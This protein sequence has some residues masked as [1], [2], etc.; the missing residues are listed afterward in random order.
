MRIGSFD[1]T[2]GAVM[3]STQFRLAE[4]EQRGELLSGVPGELVALGVVDRVLRRFIAYVGAHDRARGSRVFV[5][6]PT[7][8]D[9]ALIGVNLMNPVRRM[10]VLDTARRTSIPQLRAQLA[11]LG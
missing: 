9:L 4:L 2:G 8:E 10:E 5:L 6:T 3:E 11:L 1:G 7:T